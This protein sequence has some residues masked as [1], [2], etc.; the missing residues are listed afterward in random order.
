QVK[1][2]GEQKTRGQAGLHTESLFIQKACYACRRVQMHPPAGDE[3]RDG[4]STQKGQ[5]DAHRTAVN[6]R[7]VP[8]PPGACQ[9]PGMKLIKCCKHR[10]DEDRNTVRYHPK[11]G[12][13]PCA[14]SGIRWRSTRPFR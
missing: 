7:A 9:W 13:S 5:Q 11:L 3:E 10:G 12:R 2:A 1:G 4:E 6:Q 8:E 14:S